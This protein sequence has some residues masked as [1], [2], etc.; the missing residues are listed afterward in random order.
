MVRFTLILLVLILSIIIPIG[1]GQQVA[2]EGTN[3]GSIIGKVLDRESG[4]KIK[5]AQVSDGTRSDTTDSFAEYTLENVPPGTYTLICSLGGYAT[6]IESKVVVATATNTTQDF[7]LSSVIGNF[8]VVAKDGKGNLLDKVRVSVGTLSASSTI[9][10]AYWLMD[11]KPGRYS[12][13]ALKDG[14]ISTLETN[15]EIKAGEDTLLYLTLRSLSPPL[16]FMSNRILWGSYKIIPTKNI[17]LELEISSGELVKP[18]LKWP[19][20]KN[21]IL[22]E[23]RHF[24]L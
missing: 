3:A 21:Y 14:Y 10:G 17:E 20:L 12:I 7:K 16:V 9:S 4:K 2:E 24:N 22:L 19:D 23:R 18:K 5:G 11:L 8:R 13:K 1:C 15:A 6:S